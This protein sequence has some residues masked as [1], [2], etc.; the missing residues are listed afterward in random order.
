[1][2]VVSFIIPPLMVVEIL[3]A[4]YLFALT[5]G[6][7]PY[8]WIRYVGYGLGAVLVTVWTEVAYMLITEQGYEYGGG[9]SDL[10]QSVFYFVFYLA[11]L[12]MTI[13]VVQFSY[14]E[15]FGRVLLCCSGAY[16]TQH[17]ARNVAALFGLIPLSGDSALYGALTTVV[18][19][20]A[21]YALIWF[22]FARTLKAHETYEGNNIRKVVL[23]LSV[24]FVCIVMSRLTNDN[25]DRNFLS[26]L[27]ESVYAIVSCAVLLISQFGVVEND[28]M[29][30]EVDSM[31]EL[32]RAERRQYE[33]SRE[34]IE[35]I[36]EKCHDL[37]HQIAALRKDASEE[38]IAGIEHAVMIYDSFLKTGH[39][40]LDVILTEKKLQCESKRIQMTCMIKGE[41][42]AFMDNMDVYSLF[43]N[44]LSNAIESVGKVPCEQHRCI[45]VNVRD[46]GG[47]LSVHIEN[48]YAGEIEFAGGLPVTTKEDKNYHGFGMASM[49][50]VARKYG[51]EMTVSADGN[52]FCLDFLFPI[53]L[54]P[55][56]L[57]DS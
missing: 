1:M 44:A 38:N 16:A 2:N 22:L 45:G 3:I 10:T 32:L 40:V 50:R 30:R 18:S 24:V 4:D 8:F 41:L 15:S 12:L 55:K 13:F 36:N 47:M 17:I 11:I 49:N 26:V 5:F 27:A 35:L 28:A 14:K 51:G 20:V 6:R 21:V 57:R 9:V 56:D 43:G 7:R 48:Y 54:A 19:Y 39:D 25:P 23:S 42:V 53:P 37:K 29:H 52:K 46:M 34:N 33:L 31:T